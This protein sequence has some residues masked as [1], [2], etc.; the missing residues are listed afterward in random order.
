MIY[1]L[2]YFSLCTDDPF[3]L[4]IFIFTFY[5]STYLPTFLP[6][7][8]LTHFPLCTY[9][10][11][12]VY[13]DSH[14]L[15]NY[16]S[17]YSDPPTHLP[18]NSPAYQFIFLFTSLSLSFCPIPFFIPSN[19]PYP[20]VPPDTGRHCL[21]PSHTL[22]ALIHLA[23]LAL[24][25]LPS[26]PRGGEGRERL[27][28]ISVMS[29]SRFCSRPLFSF[30]FSSF[31]FPPSVLFLACEESCS[32]YNLT[33]ICVFLILFFLFFPSVSLFLS[34]FIALFCPLSFLLSLSFSFLLFLSVS[35]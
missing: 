11:F 29:I 21:A 16:L 30:L 23:L 12:L 15:P 2:T 26:L 35:T 5:L 13:P 7:D 9:Y 28:L 6:N 33:F 25:T 34:S 17:C 31:L 14:Y 1:L 3:F 10:P 20:S 18:A 19:S 27:A 22:L 4:S 24:L 32:N 8:L